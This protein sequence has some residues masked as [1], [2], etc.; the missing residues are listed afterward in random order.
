MDQTY[1][2]A[3]V[4]PSDF[5]GSPE[6]VDP[7]EVAVLGIGNEPDSSRSRTTTEIV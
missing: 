2:L 1:L 3:E 5:A 7:S 4:N 6:S